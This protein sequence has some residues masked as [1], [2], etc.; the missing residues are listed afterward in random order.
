MRFYNRQHCHCCGIDLH[1]KTMYLCILD[2][3]GQVLV[4]RNVPSTP[5]EFLKTIAPYRDDL[6]VAAECM[7]TWY[8][9]ADLCA[10]EGI[11]FVLGHALAMKAIH[12]GKAKNDRIDSHK[13]VSLLRGGLLPHPR[14]LMAYLG[15]VPSEY[16]SGPNVRRGSIT[17]AGNPHVRRL[18]AEAA[19]AYQGIP[20][21]G[22]QHAYRQEALPKVVCDI[23]W[24]AQLRLTTRFRRLVVRGKAKPKVAT[25]IARELTG[26]IWAIA[27][28]V[29]PAPR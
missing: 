21:I 26:F 25:A 5:E 22:R 17:K 15:L 1:V 9:L 8:W 3:A 12:G 11:V 14:E 20:R 2:S 7:F 4:H 10:A 16:S 29:S 24:K 13:I 23:A 18:L 28:E 6:V 19:W 27:R